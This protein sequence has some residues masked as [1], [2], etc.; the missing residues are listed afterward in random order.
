MAV[1]CKKLRI[2]SEFWSQTLDVIKSAR[3]RFPNNDKNLMDYYEVKCMSVLPLLTRSP[4][5][6]WSRWIVITSVAPP[7]DD[8]I[9]MASL[10]GWRVLVVGDEKTPVNWR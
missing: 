8:V 3:L 2:Y 10:P 6:L 1:R 9:Y 7:T 5:Q 4:M